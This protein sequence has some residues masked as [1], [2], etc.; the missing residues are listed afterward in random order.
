MSNGLSSIE[1]LSFSSVDPITY[2][3]SR[4]L[5]RYRWAVEL[6]VKIVGT[7]AAPRSNNSYVKVTF[8]RV[9]KGLNIPLSIAPQRQIRTPVAVVLV[10]ESK[11]SEIVL[12]HTYPPV[13]FGRKGHLDWNPTFEKLSLWIREHN[14]G[15]PSHGFYYY[16]YSTAGFSMS[17]YWTAKTED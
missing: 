11:A 16:W 6:K 9:M 2:S 5:K 1:K 8:S 10:P 15:T 14:W 3:P 17:S 4:R 7:S 12:N 13:G